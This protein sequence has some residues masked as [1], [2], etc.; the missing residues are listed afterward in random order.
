MS[1]NYNH[2]RLISIIVE[3]QLWALTSFGWFF[4]NEG[5]ITAIW[6][7]AQRATNEWPSLLEWRRWRVQKVA[8]S[9]QKKSRNQESSTRVCVSLFLWSTLILRPGAHSAAI[10]KVFSGACSLG[11]AKFDTPIWGVDS[12]TDRYIW[13]RTARG[14]IIFCCCDPFFSSLRQSARSPCL[15][16]ITS[17]IREARAGNYET[18]TRHGTSFD[19]CTNYSLCEHI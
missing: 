9:K 4:A 12:L 5:Q 13:G 8:A 19:V 15:D 2:N 3:S 11:G 16:F 18:P 7:S 1:L 10:K 6:I 14:T 17:W